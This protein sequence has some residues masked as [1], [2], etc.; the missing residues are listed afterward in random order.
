MTFQIVAAVVWFVLG[1]L[2]LVGGKSVMH[3]L[4]AAIMLSFSVLFV[5]VACIL[6]DLR[7]PEQDAVK[8]LVA[9]MR[10]PRDNHRDESLDGLYRND[11]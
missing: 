8:E 2:G 1:V 6:Y 4:V 7:H 5:G 3:E 11:R 10:E 9:R